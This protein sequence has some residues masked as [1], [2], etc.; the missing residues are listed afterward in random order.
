MDG[1]DTG[2]NDSRYQKDQ[3][4]EK[5]F[6]AIDPFEEVLEEIA[7]RG[8][9]VEDQDHDYNS[10]KLEEAKLEE[11]NVFI[12]Y[13]NTEVQ[14]QTTLGGIEDTSYRPEQRGKAL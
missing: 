12:R 11:N 1:L 14:N 7:A 8:S 13:D 10:H 3:A 9:I 5:E 4:W 2:Y 6:L